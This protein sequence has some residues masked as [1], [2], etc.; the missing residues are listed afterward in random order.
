MQKLMCVHMQACMY[1]CIFAH[2]HM[3]LSVWVPVLL[4]SLAL[5]PSFCMCIHVH[6][7][8]AHYILILRLFRNSRHRDVAA[9]GVGKRLCSL[10]MYV[11]M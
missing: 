6:C 3:C 11:C 10:Y 9:Y 4:L 2:L 8:A 7:L 5:S 1:V